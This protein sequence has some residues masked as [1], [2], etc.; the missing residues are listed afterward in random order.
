[1]LFK[2]MVQEYVSN[3]Y[4]GILFGPHSGDTFEETVW[5]TLWDKDSGSYD[6]KR[7]PVPH[8]SDGLNMVLVPWSFWVSLLKVPYRFTQWELTFAKYDEACSGRRP[9]FAVK[10]CQRDV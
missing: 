6:F 7:G 4:F 5:D 3:I 8:M 10:F 1:M 2:D 9:R